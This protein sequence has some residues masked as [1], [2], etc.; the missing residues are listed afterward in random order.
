MHR[1]FKRL[2]KALIRLRVCAGWSEPLLIT[3]STLLEISCR[4]SSTFV[5]CSVIY[6]KHYGLRSDSLSSLIWVHSFASLVNVSKLVWSG[7]VVPISWL[8]FFVVP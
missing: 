2:S 4:G 6:C 8:R 7:F 3:H 5:P 1:I